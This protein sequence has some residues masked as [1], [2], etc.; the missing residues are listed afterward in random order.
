MQYED[1]PDRVFP[2][3]RG[4][5]PQPQEQTAGVPPFNAV[6]S[7][8]MPLA[9]THP[10]ESASSFSD[11]EPEQSIASLIESAVQAPSESETEEAGE[12]VE[13]DPKPE[14]SREKTA[15]IFASA[16]NAEEV[17]DYLKAIAEL[18][19]SDVYHVAAEAGLK[20]RTLEQV[21]TYFAGA[22][23]IALKLGHDRAKVLRKYGEKPG[24]QLQV[25]ET[26]HE[27]SRRHR[28][29]VEQGTV[30]NEMVRVD[31]NRAHTPGGNVELTVHHLGDVKDGLVQ[32]RWD[33]PVLANDDSKLI[34]YQLTR[35]SAG[36]NGFRKK[37]TVEERTMTQV[38]AD[39]L[40]TVLDS[41]F[42]TAAKKPDDRHQKD[43][44][45][46]A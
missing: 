36:T 17:G 46:A 11:F 37:T 16:A 14:P 10:Q 27:L 25:L 2:L 22:A 3:G 31:L 33:V 24:P 44:G 29:L 23:D 41:A 1:V 21:D 13:A 43:F 20:G 8:D 18:E 35:E 12:V 34:R 4:L 38:D 7:A 40:K 32:E 28:E 42:G 5:I 39:R 30:Q 26:A 9:I 45:L 19:Q 15:E 6:A